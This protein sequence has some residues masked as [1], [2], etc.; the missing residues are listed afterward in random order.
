MFA[1]Y[2]KLVYS[3]SFFLKENFP[4]TNKTRSKDIGKKIHQAPHQA[5]HQ[6]DTVN[7]SNLYYSY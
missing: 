6:N 2:G 1:M 7:I 4:L 3:S 5:L